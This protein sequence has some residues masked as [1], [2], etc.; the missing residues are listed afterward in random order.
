MP[1]G[2]KEGASAA[3]EAAAAVV[4]KEATDED[5]REHLN[6][7][8][9]GHGKT[10]LPAVKSEDGV[11]ISI[12]IAPNDTVLLSICRVLLRSLVTTG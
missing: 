5:P 11:C 3:E 7:V 6:L 4:E 12:T 8:F 10:C 1:G 2:Q 9:I